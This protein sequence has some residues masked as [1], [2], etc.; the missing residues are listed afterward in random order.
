[1]NKDRVSEGEASIFRLKF[2]FLWFLR[3]TLI[4]L[5][6]AFQK[7]FSFTGLFHF[8]QATGSDTLAKNT[9]NT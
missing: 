6:T 5:G 1:M 4:P 9:W 3:H 7:Q 8:S 2:I